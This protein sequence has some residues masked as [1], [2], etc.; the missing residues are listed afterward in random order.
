MATGVGV[1][2]T[3]L[4][5]AGRSRKN[6]LLGPPEGDGP[7]DPWI[8]DFSL[9]SRGGDPQCLLLQI[10]PSVVPCH[11]ALGSWYDTQPL[12]PGGVATPP[13]PSPPPTRVH[14]LPAT[15]SINRGCG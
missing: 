1:V 8:P 6:P 14:P 12:V 10:S 2:G 4:P 5:E 15:L 9:A 3:G 11:G 7:T 13:I